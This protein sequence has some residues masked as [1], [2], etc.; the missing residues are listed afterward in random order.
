MGKKHTMTSLV[1]LLK[2]VTLIFNHFQSGMFEGL[3]RYTDTN[4][5]VAHNNPSYCALT[6][7][8]NSKGVSSLANWNMSI[9]TH[10]AKKLLT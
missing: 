8:L 2:V 10:L 5:I 9:M 4:Y 3:T 1:N 7:S 6:S